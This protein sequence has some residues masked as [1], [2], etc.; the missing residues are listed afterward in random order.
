MTDGHPLHVAILYPGDAEARRNAT[1]ENN[2]F[3]PL[4][5]AFAEDG[6]QAEPAVYH[7]DLRDAVRNQLLQDA[8]G[9]SV[10]R[11]SVS[12]STQDQADAVL[13]YWRHTVC[14][15]AVP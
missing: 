5:R 15:S 9:E 2:R 12:S 13:R 7:D 8:V 6:I 11:D 3:A 1:A 10:A 4:F 14:T